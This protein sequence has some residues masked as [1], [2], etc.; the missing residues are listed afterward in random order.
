MENIRLLKAD[1]IECKVSMVKEKGIQLLLYKTA[2]IDMDILDEVFG[3]F[4]WKCSYQEIK[5]NMYCTISIYD[6]DKK[7]WVDKQDCGVESAFGD[8]EKGEASDA[9]KRAG[10]KVGIGRELY[11]SPFIWIS[12]DKCSIK[13]NTNAQGKKTYTTSDTFKVVEIDY[14]KNKEIE[15]LVIENDKT[16][17]VV[18]SLN[19]S[20][21]VDKVEKNKTPDVKLATAEQVREAEKIGVDLDKVASFYGKKSIFEVEYDKLEKSI[22]AKKKSMG[23]R[24]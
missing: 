2:R 10:F 11:T 15:V 19:G 8:K 7:E 3:V 24:N 16:G 12:S 9:F 13:E 14:N 5:G 18:Y 17:K 23:E 6:E 1:E 21:G 4:N 20:K 22:L